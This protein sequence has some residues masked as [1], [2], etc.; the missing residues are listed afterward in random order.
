MES[1]ETQAAAPEAEPEASPRQT[2]PFLVLQFFIFPMAIVAVCVAVFVVFGLI[3]SEAKSA[4][5]YLNE[6]RTGSA[7][8]RWQAA[9]E[10]SKVLQA[11]K[12]KA[13]S[14]PRFIDEVGRTFDEAQRDDP[15]V[16]RYLALALGRI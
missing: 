7:N 16:R 14:D 9:F 3:A 13:L 11:R 2:T 5:D 4:R 8:Q 10:L 1:T 6:V 12:D 15:R